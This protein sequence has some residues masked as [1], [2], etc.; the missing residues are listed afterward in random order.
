[1]TEQSQ[2]YLTALK[3]HSQYYLYS[4]N[5]GYIEYTRYHHSCALY[6]IYVTCQNILKPKDSIKEYG[7]IL[8]HRLKRT[9]MFFNKQYITL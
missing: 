4:S 3:A 1:M 2:S 8:I 7:S 9:Y 6:A 5:I